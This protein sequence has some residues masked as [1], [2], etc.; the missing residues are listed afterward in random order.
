[1]LNYRYGGYGAQ[2]YQAAQ[3]AQQLL[4]EN[5]R[6]AAGYAAYTAHSP[7][8]LRRA[9]AVIYAAQVRARNPQMQVKKLLP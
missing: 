5:A 7:I 2:A 9:E 3:Q 4:N 8:H 6:Y 1:M